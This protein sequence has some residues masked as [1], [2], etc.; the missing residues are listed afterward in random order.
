M[1]KKIIDKEALDIIGTYSNQNK[2]L[3][4]QNDIL[5]VKKVEQIKFIRKSPGYQKFISKFKK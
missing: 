4:Q 1:N 5:K 3:V 2:F